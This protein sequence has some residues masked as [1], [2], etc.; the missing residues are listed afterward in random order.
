MIGVLFMNSCNLRRKLN[1][2]QKGYGRCKKR[3]R[4]SKRENLN[5][6]S[7]GSS[8][9][10]MS[11]VNPVLCHLLVEPVTQRTNAGTNPWFLFLLSCLSCSVLH[12]IKWHQ[13]NCITRALSHADVRLVGK[14]EFYDPVSAK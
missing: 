3:R 5:E 12:C 7:S 4:V 13:T 9:L 11:E 14:V 2:P 6:L 10:T 8:G 1:L